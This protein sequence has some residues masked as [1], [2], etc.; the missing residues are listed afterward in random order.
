MELRRAQDGVAQARLGDGLFDP[1]LRLVVG[2]RDVYDAADRD[3]DKVPDTSTA[4]G[5]DQIP[6]GYD[7][8]ASGRLRCAV[9][10]DVAAV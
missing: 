1:Q 10:D 7:V 5:R 3:V 6:G 4:R 8:L 2:Q 9:H